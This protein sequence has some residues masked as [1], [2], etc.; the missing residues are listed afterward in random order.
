MVQR[1]AGGW[2]A[3]GLA[4]AGLAVGARAQARQVATLVAQAEAMGVRTGVEVLDRESGEVLFE[5][6]AD[7]AFIPASNQKILTAVAA[8]EGLGADY[9]FSTGFALADGRLRVAAGGDPNWKT[10][11]E[12]DPAA[13]FAEVARQL[14]RSGVDAIGGIDLATQ[15]F[16]GPQRPPG[17][18][19]DQ[20]L[21]YYCAPTGGLV[22]DEGCFRAR[23]SS[24][25]G[26]RA[27]IEL[28]AP[29]VSL[30]VEGAVRLTSKSKG[31][32]YGL[33]DAGGHLVASGRFYRKAGARDMVGAV[34]DP[35]DLFRRALRR[36]LVAGGVGIGTAAPAGAGAAWSWSCSTPLT[37]ALLPMLVDSSNFH[38]EQVLRVLGAET[39][40]IGSFPGGLVA[41]RATLQQLLGTTPAN[42][43]VADGS[44]LS[45]GNRLTPRLLVSA[46]Q[47]AL[48]R[49]YGELL[50][51]AL[52][53]PGE[54]SLRH[55]FRGSVVA[56][57]VRAKTGW[58]RGASALSGVVGARVF[59]IT[60]NYD[61]DRDGLNKKLKRI[62]ERLVEAFVG[63]RGA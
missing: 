11:G 18:P 21:N 36:A 10:G 12:H 34:R 3:V 44:G 22:L 9:R 50:L 49:D 28:L 26:D 40:G 32:T 29:P 37:D 5:R 46:L 23:L 55:R 8:L 20:L 17:W 51:R 56:G 30:P 39:Q 38:A 7:E 13:I 15:V 53:A 2:L 60:M 1:G 45:R 33:R 27:R 48:H 31:A 6:R 19:A 58:I 42:W 63:L 57:Q 59:A 41:V 25:G 52:P 35:E 4:V 43:R 47:A 14:R 16:P 61:P 62:Q 54:G 24:A